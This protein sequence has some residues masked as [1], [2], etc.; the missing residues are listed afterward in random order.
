M[1]WQ[2]IFE[3]AQEHAGITLD[4]ILRVPEKLQYVSWKK[5][6]VSRDT[7]QRLQEEA[8]AVPIQNGEVVVIDFSDPENMYKGP[9]EE[10]DQ[11][12]D[13]NA[14]FF[15]TNVDK[16]VDEETLIQA[17]VHMKNLGGS[18]YHIHITSFDMHLLPETFRG[19]TSQYSENFPTCAPTPLE[20][21]IDADYANIMQ[22]LR[23]QVP[24]FCILGESGTGK[25]WLLQ[26]LLRDTTQ[27]NAFRDYN[28]AYFDLAATSP[29]EV[30]DYA[31]KES[32]DLLLV[33]NATD[34][35]T[36]FDRGAALLEQRSG[37][38]SNMQIV[39]ASTGVYALRGCMP[40]R[41]G[42]GRLARVD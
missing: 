42:P 17:H 39:Y 21:D 34:L 1:N 10:R 40:Y 14:I 37:I 29:E 5:A 9:K 12:R 28:R 8:L 6:R 27:S 7:L 41:L 25:T 26:R 16:V 18:G 24:D 20:A 3:E 19:V 15:H 13:T 22:L 30:R 23:R 38:T 2:D 32:P 4:E 35:G 11:Y 33:D 31:A 36:C